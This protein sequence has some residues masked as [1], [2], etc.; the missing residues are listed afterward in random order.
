MRSPRGDV[1]S[2]LAQRTSSHDGRDSP[3]TGVP[4]PE[5]ARAGAVSC[6]PIRF[7]S[8]GSVRAKLV[9]GLGRRAAGNARTGA[10]AAPGGR[11]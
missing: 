3:V 5:V 11:G 6:S 4:L 1:G 9:G 2:R 8:A 7:G 10:A